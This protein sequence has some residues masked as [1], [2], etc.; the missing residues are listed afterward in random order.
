MKTRWKSLTIA[1]CSM[2]MIISTTA[3]A[4]DKNVLVGN[5]RFET[6]TEVSE[7]GFEQSSNIV[8]VNGE[9]IADALSA[10]PFA[11]LKEAPI[12]LT[13]K[14]RLTDVT[15]SEIKRLKASNIYIVGGKVLFLIM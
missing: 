14:D 2:M 10:T 3:Y 13:E 11:K 12:L 5:T 8:L 15:K 4:I 7:Y 9:S 1:A 6:A